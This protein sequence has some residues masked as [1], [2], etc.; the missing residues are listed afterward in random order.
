MQ[1]LN[2]KLSHIHKNLNIFHGTL[3]DEINEQ[4]LI[5]KHISPDRKVLEIGSNYGRTTLVLAYILNMYNNN[6]ILTLESDP[7]YYDKM[8]YNKSINNLKFNSEN[9]ALSKRRLMQNGWNTDLLNTQTIEK[10]DAKEINCITLDDIKDK[11]KIHFDTLILDCE[12]AFYYILLDMP[13]IL[14]NIN[15]IIMEND[16]WNMQHKRYV[17]ETLKQKG[18]VV[19]DEIGLRK[20]GQFKTVKGFTIH[21]FWQ[22]WRKQD[23]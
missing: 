22:V 3:N 10:G 12:G 14:H 23:Y 11:Y 5:V 1:D 17:H 15:L 6:D 8:L 9:A 19:V 2:D 18:F 21:D 20:A 13:E 4:L 7:I 16:Y